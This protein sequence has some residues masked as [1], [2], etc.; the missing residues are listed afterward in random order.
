MVQRRML[1]AALSCCNL[2]VFWF[3]EL[4]KGIFRQQNDSI[5]NTYSK[6]GFNHFIWSCFDSSRGARTYKVRIVL[7][8]AKA[9][10]WY[11]N[12]TPLYSYD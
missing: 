11:K 4:G 10:D 7:V 6:V 5:N 3:F 2:W 1:W 9:L 8:M 12:Q